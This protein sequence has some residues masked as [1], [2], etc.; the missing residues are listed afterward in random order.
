M[1]LVSR[2]RGKQYTVLTRRVNL[3]RSS[4]SSWAAVAFSFWSP[5]RPLF[6]VFWQEFSSASYSWKRLSIFSPF[7]CPTL[8]PSQTLS[9]Q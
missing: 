2:A 6:K 9:M 5:V 3:M 1:K 4:S 7:L 8:H